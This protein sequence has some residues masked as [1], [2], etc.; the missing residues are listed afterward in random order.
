MTEDLSRTEAQQRP[1]EVHQIDGPLPLACM[2]TLEGEM[3]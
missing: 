2:S 3:P 1:P